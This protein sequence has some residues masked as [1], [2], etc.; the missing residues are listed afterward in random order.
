VLGVSLKH[1]ALAFASYQLP[2][3]GVVSSGI[4]MYEQDTDVRLLAALFERIPLKVAI[5]V[6][7]ER[8][9][10]SQAFLDRGA[11][12]VY[13]V[14]PFPPNIAALRERFAVS[15]AVRIL[16]MALGERDETAALH[17]IEDRE[18]HN[19]SSYHSLVRSGETALL[20]N[21]GTLEVSCRTIGSL[22]EEGLLPP[23]AGILKIDAERNDFAILKGMGERFLAAV[24]MIEY[25]DD[26]PDAVGPKPF[27]L[28]DV[29]R[30]LRARG[31]SHMAVIKRH[32]EFEIVE[33]DN[34]RTRPGD[35]G[36]AIFLHESE[37]R[38]VPG[39]ILEAAAAA[40]TSLIDKAV[41]FK[42]ECAKRLE[43]IEGQAKAIE[44]FPE[45]LKQAS[46][47][48]RAKRLFRSGS[49][50]PTGG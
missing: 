38:S 43:V 16:E 26:L 44:Q 2:L 35:W 49:S 24:V 28:S 36:N 30:F 8:G 11:E 33:I 45:L 7:A 12:A 25:W 37:F 32:D 47:L 15:P 50:G 1:A 22:V 10:F 5:D 29:N 19:P 17:L 42:S 48:E 18:A 27:A 3:A 9:G 31:Y 39:E 14:E 4:P 20:H 34:D 41:F 13:A 21:V 46:P 6:G 40:H 23:R